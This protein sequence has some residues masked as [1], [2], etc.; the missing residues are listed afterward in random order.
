MPRPDRG[1][2]GEVHVN[3][4]IERHY[5]GQGDLAAG[6]RTALLA[7]GK[8]AG[9]LTTA[10]LAAV[11]ELHMR[12]RPATLELADR[13]ELSPASHVLDLGSGLG[14]PART[15]AELHGCRV[16]GIDLTAEFCDAAT[17]I[18][19]W[20]DLSD[21][22]HFVHG[23]ATALPFAPASFDAVMTIHVAMNILAK[24]AF[25]AEAKRVL[26]PGRIF[27]AYDVLKGEG[28]PVVYPV[29]W[30][31]DPSISALATPAD[32]RRLLTEAGFAILEEIDN[33]EACAG[34]FRE[35]L[36]RVA[37]EAPD[38]TQIARNQVQSLTER[39]IR[40]VTYVCRG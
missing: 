16:T 30:A 20:L 28:G 34:W 18:S 24:D 31:R 1:H 10:D 37:G 40:V 32:M 5:R 8:D 36:A 35:V 4:E 6:I 12:G 3:A 23:D 21:R 38:V 29:P 13:M 33:T 17:T 22:V 11:D 15:L 14:G 2:S 25:Y 26:K 19:G 7:A 39:R 27:V 9:R